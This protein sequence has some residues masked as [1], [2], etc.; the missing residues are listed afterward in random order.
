MEE[1]PGFLPNSLD[2]RTLFSNAFVHQIPIKT[3]ERN[4]KL[5]EKWPLRKGTNGTVSTFI[6]W[7]LSSQWGLDFVNLSQNVSGTAWGTV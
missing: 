1:L 2:P 7:F 3:E 6:N 5:V 4:K